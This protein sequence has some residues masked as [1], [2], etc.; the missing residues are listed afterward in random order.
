MNE[1]STLHIL[2]KTS[3]TLLPS[4][5]R[6]F[7]APDGLLLTGDGV[8]TALPAGTSLPASTQALRADVE[9][10]GLLPHWPAQIALIDHEG[11]VDLCVQHA[12][13]LSWA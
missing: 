13:S 6:S 3:A 1:S 4:L 10:R 9:A 7:A 5:L 8:Y 2:S 12:R 11:F